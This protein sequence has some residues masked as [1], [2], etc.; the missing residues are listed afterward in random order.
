MTVA[1]LHQR[2]WAIVEAIEGRYD[3][4]HWRAG[5]L[6]LWP[7]ARM[8][9]FLDMMRAEGSDTAPAPPSFARR[10]LVSLTTPFT[11]VWKSR[12]DLAHYIGWPRRAYAVLLGD[13]VSLDHIDGAWHDRY[14]EPIIAA[15]EREGRRTLL[16]Q[17]GNLTRL[18]WH[19]PT[20]AANIVSAW[21]GLARA[22]GIGPVPELPDH[23]AI[24]DLLAAGGIVAPSLGVARLTRR[25]RAAAASASAFEQ[26]LR[27]ARPRIAFVVTWYAGLGPA[28]ALACRRRGIM[29]VDLQHCPQEGLHKA[30]RWSSLP[31]RGYT[32][33]PALFWTWRREDAA[34]IAGWAA[35]LDRP[36]HRSLHGGHTQIAAFFDDADP[37]TI[38]WDQVFAAIGGGVE[39]EREILI[40][41]QP[42]GGRRAIWEALAD[43]IEAS[44]TTWRWW[45]RRHPASTAAQDGEYARLLALDRPN[46]VIEAAG[47]LPL[48]ALLRHMSML[49]SLESGAAG[50]AA[51]F[52]VPAL[53][54]SEAARGPFA[55]LI[56]RGDARVVP[57]EAVADHI[58][59]TPRRSVR[60]A[61]SSATPLSV[62]LRVLDIMVDE[63]AALC[64]AAPVTFRS[65]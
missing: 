30:Y 5:D 25:A 57:I 46:V 27:I 6:D 31:E 10:A 9:L 43:L 51:A 4:A 16:M 52:G 18:P 33:L 61:A 21:G 3:V 26:V 2:Y 44:P 41:L 1:T 56:D 42:I 23:A 8:D 7:L 55:G 22:T 15:L 62:S 59:S 32:T 28:F 58:S 40:A 11:N 49:L 12:H 36:W 50:E 24:L 48:P 35:T 20:L 37:A 39:Y 47:Y 54:L 14:G 65:S 13:G 17:S 45:I 38:A 63:H 60:P 53:F 34:H 29:C 64:R 19:R